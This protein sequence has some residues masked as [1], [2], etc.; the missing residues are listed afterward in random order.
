MSLW[1][2]LPRVSSTSPLAASVP[3][4]H[5]WLWAGVVAA[6]AT[7]S[8]GALATAD[9]IAPAAPAATAPTAPTTP[10]AKPE[11]AAAS[12]SAASTEEQARERA[13]KEIEDMKLQLERLSTEYQLMQQKQR[14]DLSRA[15]LEKQELST[16]AGLDQARLE[17]ELAAL[18][19][20]VAR[21]KTAAEL[22]KARREQETD[23]VELAI[24]KQ[25]LEAKVRTAEL[26]RQLEETKLQAQKLSSEN[27]LRQEELKRVQMEAQLVQQQARQGVDADIAA[28]KSALDLRTARDSAM[29]KLIE[30]TARPAQPL[31][32]G[33]LRVSDRRIPLSG[34]IGPGTA[35]FV[36]DRIDFFN[37]QSTTEPIFIVIDSSPGGSVMEGYRIVNAIEQSPAPVHVVVKSFA[38]SM[39]AV[40]TTLAPHSYA[41]PNAIILHHQMSSGMS[42]NLTQQKE[43][44][45]NAMEWAKR[46]AD[47]VARKMG[48]SYDELVKQMY[49][50]NS[51]GDWK[52]F[53]ERAQALK[54]VD[55]VVTEVREEGLRD[56]PSGT[57]VSLP[58]W[59]EAMQTDD[60]GQ[61]FVKLPPL[62]PFD[63]WA[64]Y[65][66]GDFWRN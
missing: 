54:W 1:T 49:A 20:E 34:P 32:D 66:P 58:F 10:T 27:A 61:A 45:T 38:A 23:A 25:S 30:P 7:S 21:I 35:D 16:K 63:F 13:R 14:N 53:A 18:R 60:K 65:D 59:L 2:S 31:E 46:L 40:I 50:N 8:L 52:E 39:A 33:A 19:A 15:E 62:M 3:A 6:A 41:L 64:M 44:L 9:D 12:S 57:R 43:Q 11:G 56:Q 37:N 47:P 24:A 42:G 29:T 55:H 4:G 17:K 5:S 51:D 28:L 22:D 36:C 48:I 26:E